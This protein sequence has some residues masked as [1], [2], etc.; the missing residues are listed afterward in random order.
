MGLNIA[1]LVINKNYKEN[2]SELASIIGE[3]LV[4]DEEVTLSEAC[5]SWK[6][7]DYCDVYFSENGT[8]VF[9][10]MELGGF[11]II[12][13][14]QDTLSFVLSE[15]SMTLC[16]NYVEKGELVRSFME[17]DGEVSE[18]VGEALDFEKIEDDKSELIYHLIE[19]ILGESFHD[20]DFESKC[21]RYLLK[22]VEADTPKNEKRVSGK[23]DSGKTK[24][25]WK[26]W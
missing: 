1:G 17:S 24:P 5:E 11:E 3:N 2:I 19:I 6:G 12:A 15:S 9:S 26:F 10:S 22:A 20:L 4:F 7:D 23:I 13:G 16:I 18:N 8:L 25:W 14:K 21:S